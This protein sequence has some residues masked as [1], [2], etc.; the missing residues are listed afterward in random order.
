MNDVKLGTYQHSKKGTFYRVIGVGK[1]SETL[2]DFV[3][4]ETLYD[5]PLSKIWIRPKNMF[6]EIITLNGKKVPRFKFIKD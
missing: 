3:V 5:N 1:H 6:L 2:E 4:Y